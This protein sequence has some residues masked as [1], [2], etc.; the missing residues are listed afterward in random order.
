MFN[1]IKRGTRAG[2]LGA[3]LLALLA[4]PTSASGAEVIVGRESLD[5][6]GHCV[7]H[8]R[9]GSDRSEQPDRPIG[10]SPSPMNTTVT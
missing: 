3:S 2:V 8:L 6:V 7:H 9:L 10:R 1:V 4:G 5:G